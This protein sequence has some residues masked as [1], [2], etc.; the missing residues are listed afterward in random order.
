MSFVGIEMQGPG[1][2]P[3]VD[4][5]SSA[6]LRIGFGR[7][8]ED[9]A[10]RQAEKKGEDGYVDQHRRYTAKYRGVLGSMKREESERYEWTTSRLFIRVLTGLCTQ[11]SPQSA[12]SEVIGRD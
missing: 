5:G 9:E 12:W 2:D 1:W 4:V 7:R 8:T 10:S 3:T 11:Y 6:S